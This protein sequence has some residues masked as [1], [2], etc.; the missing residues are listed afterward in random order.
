MLML[1]QDPINPIESV[2]YR[3][4]MYV[5]SQWLI[6]RFD[7]NTTQGEAKLMVDMVVGLVA[8]DNSIT[9]GYNISKVR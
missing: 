9:T 8:D 7:F 3:P 4:W 1:K 2:C 5:F 6:E